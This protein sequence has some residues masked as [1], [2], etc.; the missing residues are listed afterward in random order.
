MVLKVFDW[1][2]L[3]EPTAFFILLVEQTLKDIRFFIILILLAL[4]MFGFPFVIL[5]QNRFDGDEIIE[6]SIDNWVIDMI[7]NQYLLA[8][9]DF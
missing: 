5:N 2:R 1:L 7:I 6:K 9:G 8:L 4:L 3:F